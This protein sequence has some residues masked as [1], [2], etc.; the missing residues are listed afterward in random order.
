[1]YSVPQIR[2]LYDGFDRQYN[3]DTSGIPIV[4]VNRG[5]AVI[6]CVKLECLAHGVIPIQFEFNTAYD[7]KLADPDWMDTYKH[8]YAHAAVTITTHENHGHDAMWRQYCQKIGC[9]PSPYAYDF[10]VLQNTPDLDAVP[11]RCT[12]C[13][14]ISHQKE[15]SKAVK[16]LKLGLSAYN[17]RC[18][19]CGGMIFE[20]VPKVS[21]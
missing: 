21:S 14:H 17:F 19:K 11:V 7:K 13:G 1:M 16:A 10:K 8:E 3:I 15:D 20:L 18:P 4:L 5:G 2:Q 9:R 12:R 6:A